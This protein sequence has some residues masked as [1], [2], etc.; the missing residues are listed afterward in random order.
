MNTGIS[1]ARVVGN[2]AVGFFSTL[3]AISAAGLSGDA[4]RAA[5]ISALIAGGLAAA[6]EFKKEAE[7]SALLLAL[8]WKAVT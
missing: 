1:W 8:P 5:L 3:T 4:M 2:G 6:L 7:A